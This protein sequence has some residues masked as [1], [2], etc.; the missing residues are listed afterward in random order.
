LQLP[1]EAQVQLDPQ[2]LLAA[3]VHPSAVLRDR[4]D[5]EGAYKLLVDDLRSARRGLKR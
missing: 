2:P 1:A 5:R 4:S 3:T